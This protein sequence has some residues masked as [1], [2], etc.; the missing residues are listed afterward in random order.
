[1][2]VWD[3]ARLGGPTGFRHALGLWDPRHKLASQAWMPGPRER[4][5]IYGLKRYSYVIN[6]TVPA[7][8]SDEQGFTVVSDF[9]WTDII[10]GTGVD[11][12]TA[13][14][15]LFDTKNQIRYMNVPLSVDQYGGNLAGGPESAAGISGKFPYFLRHIEK[16]PAGA[17][18]L[19]RAQLAGV[20]GGTVGFQIV[21]G[22]YME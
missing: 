18:M 14:V 19:A 13:H 5:K 20:A 21:L 9:W 4:Q 11:L 15:S 8:G 3:Q 7:N 1:M 2:N 6:L 17:S 22:G 10:G 16:I 12:V